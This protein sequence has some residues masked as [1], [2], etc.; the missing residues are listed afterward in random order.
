MLCSMMSC[1]ML[2]AL[3]TGTP[4]VN[5]TQYVRFGQQ[6][7]SAT[8]RLASAWRPIEA[9]DDAAWHAQQGSHRVPLLAVQLPG[10]MFAECSCHLADICCCRQ[11]LLRVSPV[12]AW[13]NE[14]SRHAGWTVGW[15]TGA[16]HA[17][18]AP[19]LIRQVLV[20]AGGHALASGNSGCAPCCCICCLHLRAAA[21]ACAGRAPAWRRTLRRACA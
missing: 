18:H 20:F 19:H 12:T 14:P 6:G 7:N 2:F 15:Q 11:L 16:H 4:V 9:D 21:P 13:L 8:Y 1:S 5:V 3:Y 10:P 17:S